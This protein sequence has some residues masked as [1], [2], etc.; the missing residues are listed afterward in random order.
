MTKEVRFSREQLNS[1][2]SWRGSEPALTEIDHRGIGSS[3]ESG[4]KDAHCLY[5]YSAQEKTHCFYQ[6]KW[7]VPVTIDVN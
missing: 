5:C 4:D 6:D 1:M 2:K 7:I 3:I